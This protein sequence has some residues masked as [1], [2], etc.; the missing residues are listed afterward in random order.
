MARSS[1]MRKRFTISLM[2][3][4]AVATFSSWTLAQTGDRS[5]AA[6]A[7]TAAPVDPHDLSGIWVYAE[8]QG[9]GVRAHGAFS[10][11]VPPMTAWAQARFDAAKPGYGPR[12]APGG[13]D[14]IGK[15]DPN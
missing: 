12:A 3:L 14:P 13:N 11:D 2:A 8:R 1:T 7:E 4:A 5:R 15:C 9:G 10:P 6:K